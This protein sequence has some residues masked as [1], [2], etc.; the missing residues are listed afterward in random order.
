[1]KLEHLAM[2]AQFDSAIWGIKEIHGLLLQKVPKAGTSTSI[3][4]SSKMKAPVLSVINLMLK[5]YGEPYTNSA[6]KPEKMP[7]KPFK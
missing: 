6:L 3:V 1:M 4:M 5:E 2:R 7:L